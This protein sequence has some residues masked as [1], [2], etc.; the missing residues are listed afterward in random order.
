MH[1]GRLFGSFISPFVWPRFGGDVPKLA[2]L[3]KPLATS[4]DA[5]SLHSRTIKHGTSGWPAGKSLSEQDDDRRCCSPKL[6]TTTT[7]AWHGRARHPTS[8]DSAAIATSA[9]EYRIAIGPYSAM[10]LG[11][12]G[13]G[14]SLG[15]SNVENCAERAQNEAIARR[16]AATRAA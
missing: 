16:Y 2:R 12:V 4:G 7:A 1:G 14:L 10:L 9:D 8:R 13:S 15:L 6:L 5:E 11:N 3:I